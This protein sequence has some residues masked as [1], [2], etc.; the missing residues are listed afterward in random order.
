KE[1]KK[2][3][4]NNAI[5]WIEYFDD[6]I[7]V[8]KEDGKAVED[9]TLHFFDKTGK[10]IETKPIHGSQKSKWLDN[11]LL[12][13]HLKLIPNREF[14][15]LILSYGENVKVIKPQKIVSQIKQYLGNAIDRYKF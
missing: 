5:D 9:I 7:G 8:T 14:I 3:Y 15:N 6:I 10:Y 1:I 13:V 4:H 2:K 11:R 12:E